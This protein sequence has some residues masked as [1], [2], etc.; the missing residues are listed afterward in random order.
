VF[1]KVVDDN[2]AF[3]TVSKPVVTNLFI[4]VSSTYGDKVDIIVGPAYDLTVM[5]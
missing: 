2:Q 1:V 3:T 4:I 5:S